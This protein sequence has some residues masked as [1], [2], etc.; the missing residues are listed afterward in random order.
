MYRALLCIEI[1][2]KPIWVFDGTPPTEKLTELRRRRNI[3]D[4][5]ETKTD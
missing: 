3:K 4:T 2:I 1:G 5:A